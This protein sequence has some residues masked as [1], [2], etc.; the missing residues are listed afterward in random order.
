MADFNFD[1]YP[2][3]KAAEF[4]F[5]QFPDHNE[6]QAP[7]EDKRTAL[8]VFKDATN[9]LNWPGYAAAGLQKVDE[10]TGA[11]IRKFV[12]EQVTGKDIDHAPTGK[13]QAKM[14]G[15]T[16]KTYN[17]IANVGNEG[18]IPAIGEMSPAGVMGFGL[19][20][21][22][23][24][25]LI[26]S[27]VKKGA[28]MLGQGIGAIAEAAKPAQTVAMGA[29]MQ[30]AEA[31]AEGAVKSKVGVSGG[32]AV[33]EQSGKLFDFKAPQSLEE[34]REW[35]PPQGAGE[36]PGKTR[37][38]EIETT[39]SDLETKPLKYHYDMMENPKAM[40]ELKLQFEN[41]PTD[42]AKKIAAYNQQIVDESA[43][44]IRQTVSDIG[45][46]NDPKSLTDAG[47]DFIASAKDKYNAEKEALGPVFQEIQKRAGKMGAT[48]GHDLAIAIGENTK[49][50]KLLAQDET[51]GKLFLQ[52]NTPKSG[53]TD[54]EHGIIARVVDEL[55]A[56]MTFKEIQDTREFL[57]K[58]IDPAN[59]GATEEISKVRSLM[60]GQLEAMASQHGP[61]VGQTFK[62]Y[63]KNERARENVEKI[64]GGK[65]ESLDQMFAAN[66]DKVVQKIFSNPNYAKVI[67]DYVGPEKVNEMISA[68]LNHGLSKAF[69]PA[70]GFSPHVAK[71]WLKAN[72]QMLAHNL[73]GGVINRLNALA[74]YGWYG[75]RFLD[76]VNPSGTAASLK[77]MLEP[78]SFIQRVKTNGIKTAVESEVVSRVGAA[79]KQKQAVKALNEALGGV[80][81]A[82]AEK[83]KE[84]MRLD[85]RFSKML[86]DATTFQQG[87][88]AIR[89]SSQEFGPFA[90]SAEKQDD[91]AKNQKRETGNQ[92]IL[93][94]TQGTKYGQVLQNAA[95]K[96][97]QSLSAAHYVL[98]QR[99]PEYRKIVEG[100]NGG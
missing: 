50:G 68:Y 1:D 3:D 69:D 20:M 39:V 38:K 33:A 76:E 10:Y 24:P 19:E 63:A 93:M 29:Q 15:F 80:N 49:V 83:L 46:G 58:A 62:A 67:G 44:K 84:R 11:P 37:L 70:K 96:G 65:L 97:D 98:S 8:E 92:A 45:G 66:P 78:G 12:T 48:A 4:N 22:Q 73:D 36:M 6:A 17:E 2:D 56:G 5:D 41:L 31:M 61:D 27:A 7:Q 60:L 85:P 74:D 40:K 99:D 35:K 72:Q 30:A 90:P 18:Y 75:K 100:K 77:A 51:T 13:E 47:Y 95:A 23:D 81:P 16:D 89:G 42:D 25:F 32:E 21:I 57:R 53:M 55:N 82:V 91:S 26:G 64:I 71:N 94:K 86:D 9:V 43:N 79:T 88:A 87:A 14:M 52:K 28:T 34:L 54:A 59:P